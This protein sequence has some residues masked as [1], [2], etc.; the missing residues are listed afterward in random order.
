MKQFLSRLLS[1]NPPKRSVRT[2][3]ARLGSEGDSQQGA[4]R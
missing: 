1:P 3:A 2:G 4:E